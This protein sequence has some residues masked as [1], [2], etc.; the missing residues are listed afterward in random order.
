MFVCVCVC[1]K[2]AILNFPWKS[3]M[4]VYLWNFLFCLDILG[5]TFILM[6]RQIFI[7]HFVFSLYAYDPKPQINIKGRQVLMYVSL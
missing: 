3:F 5:K 1:I 7:V 4:M 2:K 6:L